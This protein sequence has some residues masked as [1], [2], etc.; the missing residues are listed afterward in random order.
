MNTRLPVL[1]IDKIAGL[2]L[3]PL[4]VHLVVILVPLAAVGVVLTCWRPGWRESYLLPLTALAIVGAIAALVTTNSGEA[5]ESSIRHA[6]SASGTRARLGDHP[7]Q[8]E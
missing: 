5:L 1:F 4:V 3:H 2:P 7:D 6:A 8:G